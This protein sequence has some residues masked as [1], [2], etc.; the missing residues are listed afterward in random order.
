MKP[1]T[2]KMIED[3]KGDIETLKR[4]REIFKLHTHSG[5]D[6]TKLK[7]VDSDSVIY[8]N[9]IINPGS[10]ADGVGET[11][12]VTEVKGA[13]LGDWVLISA[14]YELQDIT[15]TGYVQANDKVEI[16]ILNE[17]GATI[18]LAS[19]TWRILVIK[20]II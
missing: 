1:E 20:K 13:T 4:E 14:P 11:V 7:I 6:S 15:V 17:S 9:A 5:F 3:M 8:K 2:E 18:D 16:R 19:G 10:L 12:Q